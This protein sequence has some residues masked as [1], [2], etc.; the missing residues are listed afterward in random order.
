MNISDV[1]LVLCPLD[2]EG[3]S[4]VSHKGLGIS[5]LNTAKVLRAKGVDVVVRPAK[6]ASS[7]RLVISQENPSHVVINALWLPTSQLADI[8]HSYSNIQFAV[9]IHSNI[10]FLQV[11]PKGISL[12][13]EAVDLEQASI[14][15]FNVAA[16]SHGG[17]DGLSQAWECPIAYLPNLYYLDDSAIEHR[18]VWSGRKLKIGAFGALRPL[19]NPTSSAFAALDIAT[20]L[21]SELEFHVNIGR[22]D[23]GGM[24][25]LIPPL[26]AIF[27]NLPYAK[28]VKDPW[29]SWTGFRRLV[30]GMDLLLQPS[31]TE[32][33]NIVTADGVA[34]GI[35][36]VV[37]DVIEWVPRYW[38]APPDNVT[39]IAR[40]GRALLRDPNAGR[41]GLRALTANNETG[42]RTW[43]EWL[44]RKI[45]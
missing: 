41:D 28:L 35:A 24:N 8:V 15:N 40:V 34:E 38:V 26:E 12:L 1:K 5:A 7:I 4:N 18:P 19:K 39:E 6:D 42:A 29:D 32:T 22:N 21:H 14:G 30:R 27:A 3:F 9:L 45:V 17:V 43:I 44:V 37:S 23:G 33:F 16:N 11:E 10:A 20:S 2:Y 36:S 13:K 25:K 31:F